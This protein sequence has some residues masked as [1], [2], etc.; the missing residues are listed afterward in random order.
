MKKAL[1]YLSLFTI[2][3]LFLSACTLSK[4]KAPITE[5]I[6]NNTTES[7]IID[8]SDGS[9][10]SG[11]MKKFSSY[12]ELRVFLEAKAA[13]LPDYYRGALGGP[14]MRSTE[15]FASKAD[16]NT[17]TNTDYSQ[18]N[19]QVAGVDEADI[20][21][22][23]GTYIYAVSYNDLFIIKASDMEVQVLAK[24]SFYSRPTELY[25]SQGKLVVI[26]ADSEIMNAGVYKKFRRQ[27]PYTFVKI[28]DLT[29]PAAPKQIRDLDFEG[30]YLDSRIVNN[31]LYLVLNN[32]NNYI[33]GESI[34]PRLVDDGR[35][36]PDLCRNDSACFAPDVYY[37]D[38]PYDS[39]NFTSI[40]TLDLATAKEPV[41]TQTYLLNSAQN[42]YVSAKNIYLTYTKYLDEQAVRLD[43]KQS[44]LASKLS[45]NKAALI[46][47]IKK[48]DSAILSSREKQQKIGRIYDNFLASRSADELSILEL[49]LSDSLKKKFAEEAKNWQQTMIYKLALT[50]SLPVY[51]AKASVPGSILNQFS[52]D[53]DASGNLRLATTISQNGFSSADINSSSASV[54]ILSPQLTLLS[55]IE[56]IAPG[57]RIY[58]SRFLGN[59]GYLITFKQTDPLYA[60]DLSNPKSPQLLGELK[61]PGFATYLHPYDENTLIALG[62]DTSSDAYGNVVTGG[63]RVSLF[64]VSDLNNPLE[65]DHYVAGAAGSNSLALYDHKAFLFDKNKNLLALPVSLTSGNTSW[66]PYFNGALVFGIENGKLILRGQID[67]SDGGKYQR[68]DNGCG[69]SCYD[70]SVRRIFYIKDSLYTLSNKYIKVNN[71][72]DLSLKQIL[73]LIP[74]SD[75]DKKVEPITDPSID[76]PNKTETVPLGP[77]LPPIPPAE[78]NPDVTATST[79]P[80]NGVDLPLD[81]VILP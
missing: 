57:E 68:P 40:N 37:F 28:F 67:H 66:R 52:L 59:R 63:I 20:I 29:D 71:L 48:T 24:L 35:I 16:T 23:D 61:V 39:Y 9:G 26:G 76:L 81:E 19:L 12:D 33:V 32:Y 49:K 42:I 47:K 56:N 25:L 14:A 75:I 1:I 13:V 74:D 77:A 17:N 21:K 60:L 34:V 30:S 22:T 54:Y 45:T 18:T 27:S 15:S 41:E 44:V 55:S 36:L 3:G 46:D 6:K 2:L 11:Q 80:E 7:A 69:Q 10:N 70:S 51:Q 43:V 62:K 73:R 78:E 79:T 58:A 5:Q 4:E 8:N 64:D 53:E 65:L 50:G 31:H 38:T 72:N